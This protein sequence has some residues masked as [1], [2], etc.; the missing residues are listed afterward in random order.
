MWDT[1]VLGIG[2]VGSFAL[3]A[4][5][6]D[7]DTISKE[8][9]LGIEQFNRLHNKGSSHGKSRV[10]RRAYFEHPNYVP[11]IDHSIQVFKQLQEDHDIPIISETGVL[12]AVPSTQSDLADAALTTAE[13]CNIPTTPLGNDQLQKRFPQFSYSHNTIG[14]FE[15]G[16]G[17][18]KPENAMKAALAEATAAGAIIWENTEVLRLREVADPNGGIS[19]VEITISRS[20][21]ERTEAQTETITAKKVVIAAGAWASRFLPCLEPHLTVTRQLQAWVDISST[22][23]PDKYNGRTQMPVFAAVI[24]DLPLPV[25]VLPAEGSTSTK[26]N[27]YGSCVKLGIHKRNVPVDPDENPSEVS[28]EEWDEMKLAI[29]K[30]FNAEVGQLPITDIQPCMY[31]MSMD[32]HF[33]IGIPKGYS[34]ICTVAGLSGHGFKMVPALGQMLADFANGKGLAHWNAEFCS[35]DR[36]G[37]LP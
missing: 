6:L 20:F 27:R 35:P 37:P 2:G 10:F 34:N 23:E 28:E 17:V 21:E 4:C 24:P 7:N 30:T 8:K 25:Y 11:W 32:G 15:P 9:V 18:I 13:Q 26:E 12:I 36:F 31:T 1:V 3:R 14:V 16:G 19:H 22:S 29:S 5:A 33:V